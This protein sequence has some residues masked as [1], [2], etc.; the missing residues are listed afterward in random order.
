MILV[1]SF[2]E[3]WKAQKLIYTLERN[4]TDTKN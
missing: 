4:Q 3:A 1:G 2:K